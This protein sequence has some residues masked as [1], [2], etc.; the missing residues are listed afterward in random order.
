MLLLTG[1]AAPS[2]K[3]SME[4]TATPPAEESS[5]ETLI[6]ALTLIESCLNAYDQVQSYT[7]IFHKEER[8]KSSKLR[9]KETI[10]IKF[11]KPNQIYMKWIEEPNKGM[12]LIYPVRD[13]KLVV[14]PG[15]I[16][17]L[18]TPKMY[19][20]PHDNLAMVHNR[21][22]ITEAGLG[23]L[24]ES[25]SLDFKKAKE[26]GEIKVLLEE[27]VDFNGKLTDKLEIFLIGED[28]YCSRSVL[29]FDKETHLPLHVEFYDK[30]NI[31]FERYRYSDLQLNV[32]LEDIDFDE[33]NPK[34]DF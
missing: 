33:N 25:Y 1:C 18:I 19:L 23:Y 26:K 4:S 29:F 22:P 3:Q 20:H 13:N 2:V 5:E 16:M 27:G 24:I 12:E 11:R 30:E 9:P 7:A 17:D 10:F 6:R 8:L 34:Y 15:G 21:H 28:Y 32:V 14:E 31:L